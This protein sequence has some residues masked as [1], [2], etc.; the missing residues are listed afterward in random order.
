MRDQD[1][2]GGVPTCQHS[3]FRDC[4]LVFRFGPVEIAIKFERLDAYTLDMFHFG[5]EK[6]VVTKDQNIARIC[7]K[8][9]ELRTNVYELF[10]FIFTKLELLLGFM[11][12]AM[13]EVKR[14][15]QVTA[16]ESMV[17]SIVEYLSKFKVNC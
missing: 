2:M 6:G 5:L 11:E 13:E 16:L 1:S 8:I 12:F 9:G 17:S 15:S 10:N 7:E 14:I 4:E 3:L